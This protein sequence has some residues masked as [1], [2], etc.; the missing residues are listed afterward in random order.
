MHMIKRGISIDSTEGEEENGEEE[1]GYHAIE[2]KGYFEEVP[3]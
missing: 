2:T 3:P 1:I